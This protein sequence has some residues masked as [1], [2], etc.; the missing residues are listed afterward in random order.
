MRSPADDRIDALISRVET[1]AGQPLPPDLTAQVRPLLGVLAC[2]GHLGEIEAA[3]GDAAGA[4]EA[5]DYARAVEIADRYG[6]GAILRDNLS[7]D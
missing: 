2:V 4:V 3:I 6:F 7:R 5:G 1:L